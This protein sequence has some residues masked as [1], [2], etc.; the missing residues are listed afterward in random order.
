MLVDFLANDTASVTEDGRI[1]PVC[2]AVKV[3]RR[4][5]QPS[6]DH[7]VFQAAAFAVDVGQEQFE[8]AYPL[9]DAGL[10][11]L[12]LGPLDDTRD[13]VERERPLLA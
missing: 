2:G 11:R 6:R 1:D 3:R 5:H 9:H 7:L 10:D 4:R 13:E 12:P 8:G